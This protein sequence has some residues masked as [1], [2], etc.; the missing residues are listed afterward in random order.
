MASNRHL[1]KHYQHHYAYYFPYIS[2]AIK[3]PASLFHYLA[4]YYFPD[5]YSSTSREQPPSRH[6]TS[7]DNFPICPSFRLYQQQQENQN[8]A[9]ASKINN[10]GRS[11]KHTSIVAQRPYMIEQKLDACLPPFLLALPLCH[12][13][14]PPSLF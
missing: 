5:I 7:Q 12:M 13:P 4:Q 3:S 6:T 2:R 10:E 11:I 9:V 14:Q 8:I 1:N